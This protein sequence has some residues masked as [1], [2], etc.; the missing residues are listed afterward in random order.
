MSNRT[1]NSIQ[2]PVVVADL[3][4]SGPIT[5]HV[6][7]NAGRAR[8]LLAAMGFHALPVVEADRIV[9]IVTTTDLA[10]NWPD[11]APVKQL[12]SRAPH[13]INRE[14]TLE[15]A[16]AKMLANEIH[17]LVIDDADGQGI[18][19]SLDLLRAL[20]RHPHAD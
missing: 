7:D 6:A 20:V 5:I 14:A 19:S 16:A 15:A 1:S 9:G 10:D 2:Q 11:D 8:D 3:M 17:H 12:M 13:S 4:S 18:L